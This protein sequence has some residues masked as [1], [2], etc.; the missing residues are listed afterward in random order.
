MPAIV[1]EGLMK[2]Y[3]R[4]WALKGVDLSIRGGEV[5]AVLGPN[6][7]GKTTLLR[8]VAGTLRPTRGRVEVMGV[9]VR[10]GDPRVKS[11]IGYVAEG[12]SFFPELCVEEGLRIVG[13][14]HGLRGEAL[15]ERVEEVVSR[16]GLGQYRGRRYAHLSRGLR[17]RAEIAAAIIHDP[18]VLI[19][20][21]PTLG[22]DVFSIAALRSVIRGFAE[23]GKTVV[24]ATHNIAE[25]MSIS[26]KVFVLNK[27]VVI[28]SGPPGELRALIG[29]EE[30]LIAKVGGDVEGVVKALPPKIRARAEGDTLILTGPVNE[31]LKALVNAAEA[32]NAEIV[33]VAVKELTWEEVFMR[34]IEERGAQAERSCQCPLSGGVEGG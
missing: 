27:G 22:L 16:L 12:P 28:A 13:S 14:L 2:R 34:L 21:E 4:V 10:P 26:D 18:P 20:D 15:R 1:V 32:V 30:A 24:I 23:S 8:A 19:L 9:E 33:S 6:G 5:T 17:R 31:G 3:G 25:A 29:A 7:A 11:L